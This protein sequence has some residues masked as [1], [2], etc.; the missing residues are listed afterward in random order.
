MEEAQQ[1]LQQGRILEAYFRLRD[2]LGK[3]ATPEVPIDQDHTKNI[4]LTKANCK[5]Q[6]R[7]KREM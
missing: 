3:D 4:S 7:K 5:C 2:V 6:E 1:L